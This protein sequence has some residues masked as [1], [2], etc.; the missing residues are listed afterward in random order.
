M[1]DFRIEGTKL[2]LIPKGVEYRISTWGC[3]AN[4]ARFTENKDFISYGFKLYKDEVYILAET[5]DYMNVLHFMIKESDIIELYQKQ[6][7]MK[8]KIGYRL[9]SE[10]TKFTE[11]VCRM[12]NYDIKHFKD[13]NLT[14]TVE[15]NGSSVEMLRSLKI[16]DLWFK[17]IDIDCKPE[18]TING[19]K[20]D[21]FDKYVKFGCA[22][23]NK[24]IFIDAD[25]L[26]Q[27]SKTDK[28]TNRP[29]AAI[30]FSKGYFKSEQISE[31]AEYYKNK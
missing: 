21:F 7:Q 9:K 22:E 24:N 28:I 27:K 31:I 20:G 23:F 2:P 15:H 26:I 17:E 10:F 14:L 16:L 13:L 5:Y 3:Y 18:I 11:D 8:K 6:H 30:Q 29:I 25:E 19:Y 1:F 12:I 4:N